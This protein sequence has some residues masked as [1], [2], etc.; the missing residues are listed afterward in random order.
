LARGDIDTARRWADDAVEATSYRPSHTV[1]ALLA[2]ARVALAEGR[3]EQAED[4]V[5]RALA[6]IIGSES[7]LH[8]AEGFECLADTALAAGSPT[9]AARLLGAADAER[10]RRGSVRFAIYDAAHTATLDGVRA[11]L[12]DDAFDAAWTEGAALSADEA[13]AYAQRGRGERKRPSSGWASLT[14]TELDVAR[15]VQDGLANKE[16]AGRLFI[17]P[18]TVQTHLT[19]IYTKLGVGSRV[20]LAQEMSRSDVS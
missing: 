11:A 13:V 20:Q 6:K 10:R 18:R 9:E 19:H 14:P 15:L 1:R 5:H 2:R 3:P 4:W 12:G 7:Y 17:S 8:V 16:I